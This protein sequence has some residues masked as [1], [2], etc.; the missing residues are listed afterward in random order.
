MPSGF[1]ILAY[2]TF[3]SGLGVMVF[4]HNTV[5]SAIT[6]IP[7][8]Q[9]RFLKIIFNFTGGVRFIFDFF[10]IALQSVILTNCG[11]LAY[12]HDIFNLIYRTSLAC[13]LLCNLRKLSERKVDKWISLTLLVIRV[14][15]QT[16]HVIFLRPKVTSISM[17]CN[18]EINSG[19]SLPIFL[20]TGFLITDFIIELYV[21]FRFIYILKRAK[22][23]HTRNALSY[24]LSSDSRIILRKFGG[25]QFWFLIRVFIAL[26]L[27]FITLFDSFFNLRGVANQI[28]VD[29]ANQIVVPTIICLI[30]IAMSYVITLESEI[31][32]A[33]AGNPNNEIESQPKFISERESVTVF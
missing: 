23:I 1:N 22:K 18:P 28:V 19:T 8:T 12:I 30:C 21:A 15:F 25:I 16:L 6:Y 2:Q 33:Y 20:M 9:L 26:S 31:V 27:T 29:V 5:L 11:V 17:S 3:L 13:F 24:G 10:Y 14:S 7:N 32:E 4:F